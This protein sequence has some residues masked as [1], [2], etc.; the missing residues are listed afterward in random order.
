MLIYSL[1]LF[2]SAGL[3]VFREVPDRVRQLEAYVGQP[4]LVA[5]AKPSGE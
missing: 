3:Q 4:H 2:L 1:F 5:Q